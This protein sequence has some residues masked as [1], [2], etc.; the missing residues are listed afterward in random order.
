MECALKK[1][2]GAV[3]R[4]HQKEAEAFAPGQEP[5]PGAA[6]AWAALALLLVSPPGAEAQTLNWRQLPS[7]PNPPGCAG[8]FAGVSGRALLVAGGANFPRATPWEGGQKVWHDAIFVLPGPE[9]EWRSG[10]KLPRPLGYGVSA[11]TREGVLCAGGSDANRHY[12]DVFELRWQGGKIVRR[13]YPPMPRPLA[14]SCGAVVGNVLYLAGGIDRPDA[15]NALRNFWSLDLEARKPQWHELQPW[16]GPPRMLA[17]AGAQAG[18]F[19]LFSGTE[20]SGDAEGRPVRRYL[21][22]AYRFT[23][24]EGWRRIADLPR[25]TVA[26]PSPAISREGKLLILSGDDG[27]LVDFEPKSMHPGFPR[28]GL[29]FDPASDTWATLE[30]PPLSRATAPVVEWNGWAVVLNGETRP[31]ERT[32]EVWASEAR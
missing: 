8:S 13:R 15:T 22:D 3:F 12:N 18:S 20:L 21:K 31:G 17:V 32:T 27:T 29:A 28:N 26:A 10:F 7:T 6:L 16:P 2:S 4:M 23:P 25:P 5:V 9:G 14:N 11:S 24:G 30:N 19:F 1:P